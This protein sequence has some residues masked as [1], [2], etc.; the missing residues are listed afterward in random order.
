MIFV[1]GALVAG[2]TLFAAS[3]SRAQDL[4][5]EIEAIVKDY[6]ATHPDEVG[7][8]AKNY[9]V[10]HPESGRRNIGRSPQA[11]LP[12]KVERELRRAPRR[13]GTQRPCAGHR[14]S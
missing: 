12:G 3:S 6:L 9:M 11:A 2:M 14:R 10:K 1:S 13:F 5:G 8:I 7:E 4:R